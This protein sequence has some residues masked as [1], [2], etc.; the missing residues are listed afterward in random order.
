MRFS[1]L[2]AFIVARYDTESTLE[3]T[4]KLFEQA[5][6]SS[7]ITHASPICIDACIL[8]SAYLLGFYT[9]SGDTPDE[10]KSLVLKKKY[11]PPG[12]DES[13]VE[14]TMNLQ[15]DEIKRIWSDSDYQDWTSEDDVQTSGYTVD[16]FEAALWAL[17]HGKD[18][19]EVFYFH[20]PIAF[21]FSPPRRA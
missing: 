10:R 7:R 18:F 6:L 14:S 12:L 9:S 2:P 19:E 17:W 16:T 11:V 13:N 5:A 8:M 3:S 1:P 4:T 15:T 21:P 20:S